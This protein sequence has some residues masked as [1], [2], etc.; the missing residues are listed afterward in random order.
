MQKQKQETIHERSVKGNKQNRKLSEK[1]RKKLGIKLC[2]QGGKEISKDL[3]KYSKNVSV[4]RNSTRKD[5]K[6]VEKRSQMVC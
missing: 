5:A 2:R 1:T 4:A 3:G 6:E